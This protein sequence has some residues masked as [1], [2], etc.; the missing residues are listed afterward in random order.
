MTYYDPNL[1]CLAPAAQARFQS[2]RLQ[3]TLQHAYAH[4]PAVRRLLDAAGVAPAK[5]QRVADLAAVAITRKDDLIDLQAKDPPFGGFAGVPPTSMRRV[6]RSPGPLYDPE[7]DK[8]DYWRWAPALWAAGFRRG[9]I[10]LN[11]VAYHLTPLGFMFDSALRVLGCGIV[12]TGPGNTEVQVAF[13][14]DFP[15]TAYVGLPSYLLAILH[16]AEELGL[17]PRRLDLNKAFVAA[18]PFPPSLRQALADYGVVARQGYGTADAGNLGYE[19]ERAD[20]MHVPLD[21]IVEFVDINTG[22]GIAPGEPGEVV[23]T[24]LEETYPLLRFGTGDLAIYTDEPCPCGRT[25]RRITGIVGRVGQAVKV[26]GMF[27]HPRQASAALHDFPELARWQL[28]VTRAA[29]Q[30]DIVLHAV[31]QPGVTAEPVW[32][33]SVAA[34][35]RAALKVRVDVAVVDEAVVPAGAAPLVDQRVWE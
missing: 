13:L 4:A 11:P 23:V 12:P 28:V 21:V 6:Y 17:D 8:P 33:E 29:H 24:L 2:A 19:C 5:V 16:K 35:L 18:E 7:G 27:V 20:G 34:A 15:V 1:E 32:Q 10:A 31:L 25:T 3:S 22:Q 30:D 9:D 26:R 14:R